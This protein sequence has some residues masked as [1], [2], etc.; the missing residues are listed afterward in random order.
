MRNYY[1]IKNGAQS[2]PYTLDQLKYHG[3]LPETMVWH[4]GLPE[5]IEAK[6]VPELNGLFVV[7][8][9]AYA[10][11]IKKPGVDWRL[12]GV[13]VALVLLLVVVWGVINQSG[14]V[15]SPNQ[16]EEVT[17]DKKAP[18]TGRKEMLRKHWREYVGVVVISGEKIPLGGFSNVRI[19]GNN[20]MEYFVEKLE[21]R[22][23]YELKNGAELVDDHV[24][25]NV[26]ANGINQIVIKGRNRG[27]N[28]RL[29]LA[30]IECQAL[31]LYSYTDYH[32]KN[33]IH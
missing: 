5:W 9:V 33:D 31:N 4:E 8:I 1:F 21:F 16:E 3:I 32:P 11:A 24:I 18:E 10:P 20:K 22:V 26:P 15:K 27:I 29:E 23:I 17:I 13:L 12:V 30:G 25:E 28:L 19:Q 14:S 2:G 6:A 7:P